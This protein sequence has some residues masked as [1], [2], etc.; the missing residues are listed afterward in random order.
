[1][2][3]LFSLIVICVNETILKYQTQKSAIFKDFK[4]PYDPCYKHLSKRS[5]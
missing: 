3:T 2:R 1:M 5:F 4:H